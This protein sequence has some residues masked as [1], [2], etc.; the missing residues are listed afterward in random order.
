[1]A[2]KVSIGTTVRLPLHLRELLDQQVFVNRTT[3]TQ[4]ITNRL[5]STFDAEKTADIE[6][7][8]SIQQVE[9]HRD[10]KKHPYGYSLLNISDY[11][12][13]AAY[14]VAD[15]YQEDL[16]EE[17]ESVR[18]RRDDLYRK[19]GATILKW[20]AEQESPKVLPPSSEQSEPWEIHKRRLDQL[21]TTVAKLASRER[22]LEDHVENLRRD[23]S[24]K[25]ISIIQQWEENQE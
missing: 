17:D 21:E 3:M 15:S 7:V 20:R 14:L 1:M 5:Y 13:V 12:A 2:R 19:L 22:A 18:N 9:A 10:V 23:I 4:E 6:G 16:F 25:V 24:D 8:H 11:V